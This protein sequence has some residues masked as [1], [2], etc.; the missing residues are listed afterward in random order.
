[1]HNLKAAIREAAK[2]E[3]AWKTPVYVCYSVAK[4]EYELTRKLPLMGEWYTADGTQHGPT[5]AKNFVDEHVIVDCADPKLKKAITDKIVNEISKAE[6]CI[7]YKM[8][9]A[10]AKAKK[11]EFE[12][13]YDAKVG[14]NEVRRTIAGKVV[15][16]K[17]NVI[18]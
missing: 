17:I 14:I 15:T 10:I 8:E 6:K 18:Q 1:M 16:R 13:V 12:F 5:A 2:K 11:G 7:S 9:T 3:K 4:K